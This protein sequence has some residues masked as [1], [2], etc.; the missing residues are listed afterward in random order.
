MT[1]AVLTLWICIAA[2]A[3]TRR[4]AERDARISLDQLRRLRHDSMPA[5]APGPLNH[6]SRPS[7]S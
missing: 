2:E 6:F 5:T 4:H 7:A 3:S 1:V